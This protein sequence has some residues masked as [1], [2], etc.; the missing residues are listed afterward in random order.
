[1]EFMEVSR[2]GLGHIL[3]DNSLYVPTYQRVYA[4]KKGHVSALLVDLAG[5]LRN[6]PS[7]NGRDYFLGSVAAISRDSKLEIVDGQQRLATVSL[8]LTAIRDHCL[9]AG[10][11]D[12]AKSIHEN[13]L[14]RYDMRS[15][16]WPARL[17][18]NE[19]D[20]AFY[21]SWAMAWPADR[22]SAEKPS[23]PSH[24]RIQAA[25][26]VAY[27]HFQAVWDQYSKKDALDLFV[28][29][30]HFL[31]DNAQVIR[32]TVR[33][34][35]D[36]YVIFETLNDRGLELSTSDLLKNLLFGRSGDRVEETR[37]RW[38]QMV[39]ALETVGGRKEITVDYIRQLWGSI[40]GL[41]RKRELFYKIKD[42]IPHQ[43][44]AVELSALLESNAKLFAAILNPNHQLWAKYGT[45][46]K[47]ALSTI[48]VLRMERLRPLLLSILA[49]FPDQEVK[50][51]LQW[52]IA[53]S[54]RLNITGGGSSG[55]TE[56]ALADAAVG[57]RK[58]K[59]TN[60][61]ELADFLTSEKPVIPSDSV[62]EHAFA[63][64]R[65]KNPQMARFYLR[66]IEEAFVGT[67]GIYVLSENEERLNLEHIMPERGREKSWGHIPQDKANELCRRLGN[68][69]L[70][71]P[72]VNSKLESRGFDEKVAEFAASNNALL[73][74]ELASKYVGSQWGEE[75]INEWQA[76]LAKLAL[77]AW[78]IEV[79][80]NRK[81]KRKAGESNP[82]D[83]A[84]PSARV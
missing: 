11:E 34:A 48:R 10:D 43:R 15:R 22:K 41:T 16:G 84:G 2:E 52:L 8:I 79:T 13:Y 30:V 33:D 40:H 58:R 82:S 46:A 24:R 59:I 1:M 72:T 21:Q 28:D 60:T 83:K 50:Q 47:Q 44:A 63:V 81:R 29:W 35:A 3:A 9:R 36:A 31:K 80:A 56:H 17:Q 38:L 5:A 23:R 76:V 66:A 68:M 12:L 74:Q 51:A 61:Q 27:S 6:R 54:V 14:C 4:W 77:K 73:T 20:N 18:L 55:P 71:D 53:A 62:F 49:K 37:S 32:V 19:S 67:K 25:Y 57:I 39:G 45:G 69:V 42:E 65:V 78:S 75:Q 7:S 64:A 70:L 26:R